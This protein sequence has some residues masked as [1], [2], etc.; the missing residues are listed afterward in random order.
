MK[1]QEQYPALAV[2]INDMKI[3]SEN[4]MQS[5][6]IMWLFRGRGQSEK[7]EKFFSSD[8]K[9]VLIVNIASI[10][11]HN[12]IIECDSNMF[13]SSNKLKSIEWNESISFFPLADTHAVLSPYVIRW[14][15]S[16]WIELNLLKFLSSTAQISLH[17][18]D[19]LWWTLNFIATYFPALWLLLVLSVKFI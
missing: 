7:H 10:F 16:V 11:I 18:Y 2:R 15:L 14:P 3:V 13:L 1:R 8:K 19:C 9:K 4:W 5:L 12:V 6:P 17:I